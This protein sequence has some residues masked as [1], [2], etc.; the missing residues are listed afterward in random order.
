LRQA[1][2]QGIRDLAAHFQVDR[3]DLSDLVDDLKERG[4]VD[5]VGAGRGTRYAPR[6]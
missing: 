5:K 6:G 3:D 4:L 1:G 2:A